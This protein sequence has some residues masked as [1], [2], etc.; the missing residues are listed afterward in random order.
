MS[1]LPKNARLA[2]SSP[3]KAT[4]RDVARLAGVGSMT[5]S[6]VLNDVSG[7][8][9]ATTLFGKTYSAPFGIPPYGSSALIAY[10]GPFDGFQRIEVE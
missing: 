6:R 2:R 7:R 9:Q 10:R 3:A 4:I 8:D 5:V 1:S